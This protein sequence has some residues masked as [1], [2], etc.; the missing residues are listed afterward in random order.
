MNL[1]KTF[2]VYDLLSVEVEINKF[3]KDY[4]GELLQFQVIQSKN[5]EYYH[6]IFLINNPIQQNNNLTV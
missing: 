4:D 6:V 3:L 2:Q 1:V 5:E